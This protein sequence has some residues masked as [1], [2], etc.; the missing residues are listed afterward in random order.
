MNSNTL[1][2][3]ARQELIISLRSRSILA[4]GVV[5][6]VLSL[7]ISYFG[8]VTAGAAGL[9]GFERTAASL[10]SL[11]LYL[12]PLLGLMLGTLNMSR[13]R[14][15][16][17]LLFAQPVSRAEILFGRLLG[18]FAAMSAAMFA[19]FATAAAVILTQVGPEGFLRFAGLVALSF[20]LAAIFLSVGAVCGLLS[21]SRT[22]AFGLSL[23]VWF[24]FVMFYD[25]AVIGLAF[26]LRERT[27][28]VV[29]FLSLFG[30]PVDLARV[31]SLLTLGDPSIFGAAGAALLKF[32]GGMARSYI[33][34]A[35]A[36]GA[37]LVGPLFAAARILRRIDL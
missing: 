10:L 16:N 1:L 28:N 29:I 32:L 26:V 13:D 19:G 31:S 21:E 35:A 22:R 25:L 18:L 5:F 30:N 7:A 37:W 14:A 12:V 23:C 11:V 8:T 4:F 2:T 15:A 3:I 34:L 17:E 33:A 9:Q 27:A 6:G 36:L 20:V 24:F